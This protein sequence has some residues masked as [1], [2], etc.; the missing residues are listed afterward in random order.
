MSD[1]FFHLIKTYSIPKK[2]INGI[3]EGYSCRFRVHLVITDERELK[4]QYAHKRI[5]QNNQKLER[6][7]EFL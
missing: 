2:I 3:L 6:I 5:C 1:I 4:F 7:N